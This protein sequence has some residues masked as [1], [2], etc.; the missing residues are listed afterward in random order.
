MVTLRVFDVLCQVVATLK[1]GELHDAGRY[2][3]SFNGSRIG[4]GTY[5]YRITAVSA[6]TDQEFSDVKQ[7]I[8]IK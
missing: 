2:E 3:V 5:S 1:N 8:L 7:M 6:L 4:S